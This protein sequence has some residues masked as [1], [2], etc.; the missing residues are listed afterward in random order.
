M[1]EKDGKKNSGKGEQSGIYDRI[2]KYTGL[3]GGVQAISL[4]LAKIKSVL[5]GPVGYGIS[6]NL[7]R[8][9]DLVKSSTNLGITTVAVP[10]ISQSSSYQSSR[11][12]T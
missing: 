2:V 6:E 5:L 8:A 11:G 3:F 10:E 12:R 1:T 9:T 4:I 7:N